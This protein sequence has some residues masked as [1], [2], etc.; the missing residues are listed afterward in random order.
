MSAIFITL[1]YGAIKAQHER[2]NWTC[3][4]HPTC[5]QI[6]KNALHQYDLLSLCITYFADHIQHFDRVSL[7]WDLSPVTLETK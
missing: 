5:Y 4:R 7:E 3:S 6:G 1:E 2:N